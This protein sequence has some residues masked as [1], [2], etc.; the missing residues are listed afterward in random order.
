MQMIDGRMER[1]GMFQMPM[2]EGGIRMLIIL[3]VVPFVTAGALALRWRIA[4]G[5]ALLAL[6]AGLVITQTR[7]AWM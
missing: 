3:A 4:L 6:L 1:P 5:A 2:T 7:S